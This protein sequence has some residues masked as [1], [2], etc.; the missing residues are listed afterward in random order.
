MAKRR[1]EEARILTY[2]E[3]APEASVVLML[4]LV[5]EAVRKRTQ[6]GVPVAKRSHTKAQ[7]KANSQ[8]VTGSAATSFTP[9]TLEQ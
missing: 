7:R 2:F 8:A 4:G 1:S 9:A 6:A 3:S 5:K